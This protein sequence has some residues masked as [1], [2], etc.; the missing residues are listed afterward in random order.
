[1]TLSYQFMHL[2]RRDTCVQ[3]SELSEWGQ[4]DNLPDTD[5]LANDNSRTY[6][7]DSSYKFMGKGCFAKEYI[8]AS[9][10]IGGY[11]GAL[12]NETQL[13]H[14]QSKH[15]LDD[16][17]RVV[18]LPVDIAVTDTFVASAIDGSEVCNA[19]FMNCTVGTKVP[20][21]LC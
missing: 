15:S 3:Y 4:Q 7:K 10:Y 20:V 21:D 2:R 18:V 8:K 11:G 13:H 17:H 14:H 6:I 9:E 16:S 12:L 1:M 19:S 5:V